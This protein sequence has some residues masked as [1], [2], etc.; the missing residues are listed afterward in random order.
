MDARAFDLIG[1][2]LGK[3]PPDAETLTWLE[4]GYSLPAA[5]WNGIPEKL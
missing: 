1:Y 5:R 2:V 4:K 3:M